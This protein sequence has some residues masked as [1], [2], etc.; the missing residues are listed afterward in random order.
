VAAGSAIAAVTLGKANAVAEEKRKDAERKQQLAVAA[1]R[2]ANEQNRIA[3]D[4]EVELVRLLD[5]KLRYVPIIQNEREQLIDKATTRL[6]AAA[7]AMTDLRR[8]VEWA[9]EDEVHNWKSLA[10]AYQAAARVNLARKKVDDAMKQYQQVEEIITRLGAVDPGDLNMR[11]NLMRTR[12]EIGHAM[13]SEVGDPDG[14]QRY[15]R[16]ALEISRECLAQKPEGDVYKSELANSLG[17]VALSELTLGHLNEARDLFREEL[18]TR[19]SFSPAVKSDW[20]SRREFAGLLAQLGGLNVRLGDRVEARKLYEKCAELREKLAEERPDSWPAQKDLGLSYSGRAT[21]LFPQGED[22]AGAR[23]LHKKAI[24]IFKKR[25]SA[26]PSDLET[27]NLLAHTLYYEATCAKR[28]GDEDGARAGF[29]ECLKLRRELSAVPKATMPRSELMLAL[30]RCGEFA[31]ASR[32][33]DS[34]V[35]TAPNDAS[36]YVQ[37]A[38]AH[39]LVADNPGGDST[40]VSESKKKAINCLREAIKKGW[41]DVESLATDT[42]LEPISTEPEFKKILGELRAP[43]G[44]R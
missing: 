30:A 21:M 2:A 8:D 36:R 15:L 41:S 11:A 33:A 9:P 31:E 12:R 28:L 14:A 43:A 35:A 1:A 25:S 13:M 7:K 24:A 3:V 19:E 38:R 18:A 6:V 29:E 37:A 22:P 34:L 26:D 10:R 27:K 4:A 5:G 16:S 17:Q 23:V 32:I 44:K 39:A 40:H 42:D 20:E